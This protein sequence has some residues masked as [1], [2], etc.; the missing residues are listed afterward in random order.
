MDIPFKITFSQ[1]EYQREDNDIVLSDFVS[2]IMDLYKMLDNKV[3]ELKENKRLILK[4]TCEDENARL[5]MDGLDTIPMRYLE[6]GEDDVAYLPPSPIPVVLY[7]NQKNTSNTDSFYPLIPGYYRIKVVVKG[8]TYYSWLKIKPKQITEEQWVSMRNDIEESLHG[9]AQDLIRKNASIGMDS[10]VPIPIHILRKLYVIKKDFTKW[11]TAIKEIQ[12]DPRMR[13]KKEYKLVLEGKARGIDATSIYYRS[14][15][16]ESRDYIYSPSNI[17]NYDLL[18]NQWIKKIGR[19][20]VREM[21]N[22]LDY[23]EK[24]KQM[25]QG[26]IKKEYRYH[27][28]DHIQIRLKLKVLEELSDYELFVR[29][30]RSECMLL[31]SNEW[32]TEVEEPQS[33]LLPHSMHLDQRYK[34][35]FT[36]YRNLKNEELSI[37]LDNNYDYY[38]KRTD[39]LYEIW[40]FLQL[41]TGLQD[42]SV[43]FEVIKGW[44]FDISPNSKSIQIPF[45][46]QGTTVEFKRGN[47]K[48]SLVYDESLPF[49]KEDTILSKPIYAN[50]SHNRP[51]VRMDLYTEDEYIGT[52][53][54]DFKYRPLR[55]IWDSSRLIGSRQTDTMRQLIA[56]RSNMESSFLYKKKYPGQW[57]RYR[58]VHEV[59]A[60]YPKHEENIAPKNPMENY[61]I[62]LIELTPLEQK[63]DFHK[64]I[65]EAIQKIVHAYEG[66]N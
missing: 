41:V 8:L 56:Y 14:R 49:K 63:K 60:L 29:R 10:S 64:G 46:E 47:L 59:W 4:F 31:L 23:L 30:V 20:I 25:V 3:P 17:R 9:L 15:H 53:M 11:I 39:L 27:E 22:L 34:K 7:D 66:T 13:I 35:I 5:Y 38:W 50:Y 42:E 62:R 2:D 48:L 52:I 61:R 57:H 28:T 16:P 32:I 1:P 24:H 43:G 51:D 36:L 58:P 37:S 6:V 44:I 45:L 18:E 65:A 19:F 12:A 21:N 33:L 40:G 55:F 26:E 54:V